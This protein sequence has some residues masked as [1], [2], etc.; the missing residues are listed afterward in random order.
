M[1][2]KSMQETLADLAKPIPTHLQQVNKFTKKAFFPIHV[3]KKALYFR[4]PHHSVTC[5]S[6]LSGIYCVT[7]VT[8][9][10]ACIDGVLVR[11][12]NGFEMLDMEPDKDGNMVP[13]QMR[14]DPATNSYAQAFKLA[15]RLFGLGKAG[16]ADDEEDGEQ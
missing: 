9:E 10:I 16:D 6:H 14:G 4:A 15:C 11:S 5:Q 1:P 13:K 12:A 8:I 2:M 7:D 3:Y